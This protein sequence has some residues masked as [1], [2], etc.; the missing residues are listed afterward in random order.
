MAFITYDVSLELVGA[1]RPIIERLA[2]ADR[3]L[4]DQVRRAASS[5]P[6]NLAEGGERAGRD[7]AHSFHIAAGS[8]REVRAALQVALGWG[9]L[10]ALDA[11]D[12]L[13]V[14]DRLG[15]LLYRLTHR[16]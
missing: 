2:A 11:A 12:A 15:A 8:A 5:V 16:A 14:L 1:L 6:L 3:N 9:Y 4:A 10:A 13:A 7:R